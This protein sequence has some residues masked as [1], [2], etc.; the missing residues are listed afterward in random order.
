MTL[1]ISAY[2]A[3]ESTFATDPSS[4]G[5]GYTAIATNGPI[6]LHKRSTAVLDPGRSTGRMRK[7]DTRIGPDMGELTLRLPARGYSTLAA[8]GAAPSTTDAEDL[9]LNSAFGTGTDVNG[10]SASAATT[11]SFTQSGGGNSLNVGD[12]LCCY[13]AG[14]FSDRLQWRTIDTEGSPGVYTIRAL[15]GAITASVTSR[16]YR[17]WRPGAVP[18]SSNGSSL[19]AH[20]I[21]SPG[22]SWTLLGGRPTALSLTMEAGQ[23]AYW[24]VTIMFDQVVRGTKASLPAISTFTP[25][26]IVATLSAIAW[27]GTAYESS[28]VKLTWQLGTN[29]RAAVG[30]T[31]GRS[32][33]LVRSADLDIELAPPYATGWEDDFTAQTARRFELTAGQSALSGGLANSMHL[34]VERAQ[35][36]AW[37]V[38]DDNNDPRNAVPISARDPGASLPYWSLHRA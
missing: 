9:I 8:V 13:Q 35:V 16:G 4:D 38:E 1:A 15:S 24:E 22:S 7:Q 37:S 18:I 28:R 36:G 6:T 20:V 14:I 23:E 33:I 31:N 12:A 21:M 30:A 11:T 17:R 10:I 3:A 29:P 26:S 27:G 34:S 19:A 5:S 2:L 32:D 25:P